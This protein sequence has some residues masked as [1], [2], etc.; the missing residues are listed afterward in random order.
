M[1]WCKII[2]F[3]CHPAFDINIGRWCH[4]SYGSIYAKWTCHWHRAVSGGAEH[5]SSPHS[6]V[7]V[8]AHIYCL[9]EKKKKKNTHQLFFIF[10]AEERVESGTGPVRVNT[11]LPLCVCVLTLC[12]TF[13]DELSASPQS[14]VCR[15]QCEMSRVTDAPFARRA[16]PDPPCNEAGGRMAPQRSIKSPSAVGVNASHY[17]TI[18]FLV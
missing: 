12:C 4:E 16:T 10:R 7:M 13:A 5:N 6:Q 17:G 14:P 15:G 9:E 2:V 11:C 8:K 1:D 3:I 18:G